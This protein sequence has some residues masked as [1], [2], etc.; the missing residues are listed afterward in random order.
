MPGCPGESPSP[1]WGIPPTKES[2]AMA[3]RKPPSQRPEL[4]MDE[5]AAA[6]ARLREDAKPA[7]SPESGR[8]A[9]RG[10]LPRVSQGGQNPGHRRFG[11]VPSSTTKRQK[12]G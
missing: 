8:P 9:L 3:R 10:S 5:T 7:K 4:K 12:S 6:I 11:G 2:P 1:Y